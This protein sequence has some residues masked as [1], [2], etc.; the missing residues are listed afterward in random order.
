M[1]DMSVP[2]VFMSTAP[3][4]Q[5]HCRSDHP[6]G[7]QV[8]LLKTTEKEAKLFQVVC[9]GKRSPGT[10]GVGHQVMVQAE[11]M[12]SMIYMYSLRYLYALCAQQSSARSFIAK[13]LSPSWGRLFLGRLRWRKYLLCISFGWIAGMS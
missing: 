4:L 1:E 7:M 12:Y 11:G 6:G 13:T 2:Y 3:V 5:M 9:T 10:E 8:P